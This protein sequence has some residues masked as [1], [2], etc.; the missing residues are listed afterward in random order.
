MINRK[1]DSA[2][3]I[4]NKLVRDKIPAVIERSGKALQTRILSDDEYK[5]ELQMKLL[6]EFGE[7]IIAP[8]DQ[9]AIEELADILE[10]IHAFTAIHGSSMEELEQVRIKKLTDR[11]GF[12]DKIFLIEVADA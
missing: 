10:V 5:Q 8:N 4:Y 2:M 6:E 1:K 7:Y 12:K 11:G 3:P 9:N